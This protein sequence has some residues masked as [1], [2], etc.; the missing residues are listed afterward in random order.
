MFGAVEGGGT[1][2]V[3]AVGSGPGD[4]RER[5]VIPTAGPQETMASVVEYLG[6]FELEAVGIACFGPL[7][8]AR[9]A[10]AATPPPTGARRR[11]P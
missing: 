3:C 5:T 9:G 8:L 2:F 6:R 1:K 4:V 7:D 10:I 11:P